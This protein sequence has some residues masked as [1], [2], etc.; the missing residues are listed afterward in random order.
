MTLLQS[1]CW[2]SGLRTT[3]K[4]LAMRGSTLR[5]DASSFA[6][7]AVCI[8]EHTR[9][10][11]YASRTSRLVQYWRQNDLWHA[12]GCSHG[13][14]MKLANHFTEAFHG[15][16][17]SWPRNDANASLCATPL[18]SSAGAN[19]FWQAARSQNCA[20]FVESPP[21]RGVQVAKTSDAVST[22]RCATNVRD[23]TSVGASSVT[24]VLRTANSIM[25]QSVPGADSCR[26]PTPELWRCNYCRHSWIINGWQCFHCYAHC[27]HHHGSGNRPWKCSCCE[28]ELVEW[29]IMREIQ[30]YVAKADLLCER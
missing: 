26:L 30:R 3:G 8:I 19:V 12:C 2:T 23:L 18:V 15:P 1:L 25:S 16:S 7:A 6:S 9:G 20:A 29:R 4:L 5:Y 22:C 10:H 17:L 21:S 28:A 14:H 27:K 11:F 24:P 13:V